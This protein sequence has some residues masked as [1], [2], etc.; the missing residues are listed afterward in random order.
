MKKLI[1]FFLAM[2]IVVSVPLQSVAYSGESLINNNEVYDEIYKITLIEERPDYEK[3]KLKNK[4]TGE[5]EYIESYL[6]NLNKPEYKITTSADKYI[7]KN[8]DMKKEITIE[9]L[10]TGEIERYMTE[11]LFKEDINNVTIQRNTGSWMYMPH[12]SGRSSL[13]Q[14]I[15]DVGILA[16]FLALKWGKVASSFISVASWLIARNVKDVYLNASV[17]TKITDG[18]LWQKEI[19]K[20]YTDS[21]YRYVGKTVN[22]SPRKRYR[23]R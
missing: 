5:V 19:I 18:W 22:T 11:E 16:S 20:Y 9:N 23:A 13:K 2:I 4:N 8:N 12:L 1:S 6:N 3:I 17:Y 15:S 7:V 10:S 14:T 21:S